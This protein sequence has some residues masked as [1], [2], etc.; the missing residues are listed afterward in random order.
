MHLI[1][2]RNGLPLPGTPSASSPVTAIGC[3]LTRHLMKRLLK[4]TSWVHALV[5]PLGV[6][7]Q[8]RA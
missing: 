7:L 6:V 2:D 1:V 8:A 4:R 5:P 3:S